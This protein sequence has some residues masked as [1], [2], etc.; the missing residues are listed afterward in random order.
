MNFVGYISGAIATFMFTAGGARAEVLRLNPQHVVDRILSQGLTPQELALDEQQKEKE[1]LE[2]LSELDWTLGAETNFEED[3]GESLTGTSNLKDQKLVMGLSLNKSISSGTDFELGYQRQSQKSEL[4]SF[5]Q[6]INLPEAQ[7]QDQLHLKISQHLWQNGFGTAH[8]SRLSRAQEVLKNASSQRL[9]GLEDALVEGMK[10]YWDAFVAQENLKESL[11]AKDRY[12]NLVK[13]VGN[14]SRV[15][16]TNPGELSR[17]QAEFEEQLQRVKSN[18]LAYLT[19]ADELLVLLRYPVGQD[20]EFEIKEVLP[21]LPRLQAKDLKQL[22]PYQIAE[23]E[24]AIAADDLRWSRSQQAPQLDLVGEARF[25]GVEEQPSDA[26]AEMSGL[27]RPTYYMGVQFSTSLDG[28]QRRAEISFKTAEHKRKQLHLQKKA[29]ELESQLREKERQSQAQLQIAESA[30]RMVDL[31]Q[32]AV[33]ELE[34]AYRQGRSTI[35]DVI[36][37]YNAFFAAQTKKS[38]AIGDYHIALNELA[39]TRDE[40]IAGYTVQTKE[41][42]Q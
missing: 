17:V 31:R 34:R 18:S 3:R 16:F 23:K 32:K 12:E 14:K 8:R 7:T 2:A 41:S 6:N 13:I 1:Y 35:S 21:P 9:E 40:L 11:A 19:A 5:A 30:G 15:G 42:G 36:L 28:R 25:T 26:F 4:S 38:R 29:D 39:S 20:L 10:K 37:A 27:G 24:L 22:R 33:K